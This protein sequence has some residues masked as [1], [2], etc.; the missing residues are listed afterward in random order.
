M[1]F[2]AR[3]RAFTL[4]ELLVILA[5]IALVVAAILPSFNRVRQQA[6]AAMCTNHLR[7]LGAA[8]VSY[9][10]DNAGKY[11]SSD[12]W[13]ASRDVLPRYNPAQRLPP[14]PGGT[15]P[16][17]EYLNTGQIF[18]YIQNPDVYLCPSD[19]RRRT[20][21]RAEPIDFVSYGANEDI[22]VKNP[23][24]PYSI[25]DGLLQWT[26][27]SPDV[28]LTLDSL[29]QEPQP[30]TAPQDTLAAENLASRVFLL[31]EEH[32]DNTFDDGHVSIQEPYN[33]AMTLRHGGQGRAIFF[34][35]HIE[36]LEAGPFNAANRFI[37]ARYF[38][39]RDIFKP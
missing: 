39:G 15:D 20:H 34:D 17:R 26:A 38:L 7:T 31:V 29:R 35:Q 1:N 22:R 25:Q 4:V 3:A 21:R 12:W 13:L 16:V 36:S 14:V 19:S 10:Q 33:D 8:H 18:P 32:E 2:K 6:Y 24:Q 5:V 27:G 9:A 23:A 37:R 11:P 30:T 28:Y